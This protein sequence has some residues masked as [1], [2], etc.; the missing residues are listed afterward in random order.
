MIRPSAFASLIVVPWDTS[1]GSSVA[2]H[3]LCLKSDVESCTRREKYKGSA[4]ARTEWGGTRKNHHH[5][6]G[7]INLRRGDLRVGTVMLRRFTC[8]PL[9][10]KVGHPHRVH[11]VHVS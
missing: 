1:N 7:N 11:C 2:R 4:G 6:T 3:R 8:V 5:F 9:L 10:V